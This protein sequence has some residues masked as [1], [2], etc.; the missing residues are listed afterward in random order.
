MI[1]MKS[2]KIKRN[3]TKENNGRKGGKKKNKQ[4]D[5]T[6]PFMGVVQLECDQMKS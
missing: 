2:Q 1:G 6:T 4:F 3:T 5:S